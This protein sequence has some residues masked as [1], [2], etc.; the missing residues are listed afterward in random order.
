MTVPTSHM[1]WVTALKIE[2]PWEE[3]E[4]TKVLLEKVQDTDM[5]A[6]I[7]ALERKISLKWLDAKLP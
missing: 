7:W 2:C 4:I 6:V 3:N 1:A 5:A